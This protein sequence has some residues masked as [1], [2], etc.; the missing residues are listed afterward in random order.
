MGNWINWILMWPLLLLRH[1]SFLGRPS[2]RTPGSLRLV[3]TAKKPAPPPKPTFQDFLATGLLKKASAI[4]TPAPKTQKSRKCIKMSFIIYLDFYGYLK[5]RLLLTFFIQKM[6]CLQLLL[7]FKELDK[8]SIYNGCKLMEHYIDLKWLFGEIRL[9]IKIF[10][11]QSHGMMLSANWTL[12]CLGT[13]LF[14]RSSAK[15]SMRR[16]WHHRSRYFFHYPQA[17]EKVSPVNLKVY[18]ISFGR[19][20]FSYRVRLHQKGMYSKET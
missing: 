13:L 2:L 9:K 8:I 5:R 10:S 17:E 19:F 11:R 20:P 18:D 15:Q 7:K 12:S 6:P 14:D 1:I 3:W 16:W 4:A